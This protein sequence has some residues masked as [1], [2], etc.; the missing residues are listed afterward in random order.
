VVLGELR[1]SVAV[2]LVELCK[3][4]ATALPSGV[5]RRLRPA[6]S[7]YYQRSGLRPKWGRSPEFKK[8]RQRRGEATASHQT[9]MP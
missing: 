2:G 4:D 8:A 3:V 7:E 5:R 6:V 9:A 1:F